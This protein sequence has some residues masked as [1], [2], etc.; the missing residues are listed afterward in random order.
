MNLI[1]FVSARMQVVSDDLV[2][3]RGVEAPAV[4]AS[5][6]G[7]VQAIGDPLVGY[8]L[9]PQRHDLLDGLLLA[10]LD[11]Q[12]VA[13]A[14]IA[15]RDVIVD[16]LPGP[17]GGERSGGPLGDQVALELGAALTMPRRQDSFGF[18]TTI[19]SP[20]AHRPDPDDGAST[21]TMLP[22]AESE[23][24][25]IAAQGQ[26]RPEHCE[27]GLGIGQQGRAGH[28]AEIDD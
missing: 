11:D 3:G 23:D 21:P 24:H 18:G 10:R 1:K 7:V 15:E 14:D 4:L 25:A 20:P 22:Q 17:L 26:D 6:T 5:D 19:R 13:L 8:S 28:Q 12:L 9:R 2:N 16:L 27:I